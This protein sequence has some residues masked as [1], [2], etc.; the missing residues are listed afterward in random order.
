[1]TLLYVL[2]GLLALLCF[3]AV[4]LI[5]KDRLERALWNWKNPPEKLAADR[6]EV[7]RRL[8]SPD[9]DFYL[10]HLGRPVPQALRDLYAN[11]RLILSTGTILAG[12]AYITA[13]EPLDQRALS[14]TKSWIGVE[15][16]P[17][18]SSDGDPIY[19]RPGA[20]ESDAVYVTYHDGS[21]T[22]QVS[23]DVASYLA[24]LVEG[25]GNAI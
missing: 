7:E 8:L 1:M 14:E 4:T 24:A 3:A 9:W 12:E 15:V 11:R 16:V 10:E 2:G 6:T 17:F 19:L 23:N 22:E 13:F 25:P 20:M 5:L 18:A 21:D